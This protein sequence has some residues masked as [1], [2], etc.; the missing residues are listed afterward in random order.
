M[1][2]ST[3]IRLTGYFVTTA[4]F[5]VSAFIPITAYLYLL[6]NNAEDFFY[7]FIIPFVFPFLYLFAMVYFA[8]FHTRISFLFLPKLVEGRWHHDS[9]EAKLYGVRISADGIIKALL[10]GIGFVPFVNNKFFLKFFLSFYG[11]KCGK[12]VFLA[13]TM[14]LD[15]GLLEI[16]DNCFF[17]QQ[18][19]ISCHVNEKRYLGIKPVKIGSNVTVGGKTI[20][21]P[22][23][24]IGDNV[25][26]GLLS[27]V[28]K[29]QEIPANSGI[30]AGVPARNVKMKKIPPELEEMKDLIDVKTASDLAILNNGET[31]SRVAK[32]E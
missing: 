3:I 26:V 2:L 9:D 24:K 17:G 25:I 32:N 22:G 14:S 29:D 5:F 18:C 1:R 23:A 12:N 16:G 30:W 20:I 21:A 27:F 7:W 13:S 11:L 6:V 8:I 10:G 28:K 4:F 19:I 31:N 15:S